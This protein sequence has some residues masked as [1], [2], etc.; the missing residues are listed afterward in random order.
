MVFSRNSGGDARVLVTGATEPA[1]GRFLMDLNAGP[2]ANP[3]D[4]MVIRR[5]Q[6]GILWPGHT[7]LGSG[8]YRGVFCRMNGLRDIM[9]PLGVHDPSDYDED[10]TPD[11]YDAFPGDPTE[12][13]DTDGDGIGDNADLDDDNDLIP[14]TYELAYGLN[15]LVDDAN[16][17]LDGDGFTNFEEYVALTAANDPTSFPRLGIAQGPAPDEITLSWP[18]VPGRVYDLWIWDPPNPAELFMEGL[19]APLDG[20]IIQV[21]PMEEDGRAFYYLN[22]KLQHET[23]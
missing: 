4:G 10:G 2:S 11:E 16:D 7:H 21:V 14:D 12:T 17:D 19:V 6:G 23:P 8:T 22:I 9:D 15:P 13:T 18:G 3:A 20:P 5:D 1:R